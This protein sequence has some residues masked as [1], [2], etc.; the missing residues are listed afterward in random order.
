MKTE[1][2]ALTTMPNSIT[3]AKPASVSPPKSASGTAESS[4]VMEVPR[5]RFSVSLIDWSTSWRSGICLYLRRFSRIRS[6]T[7]TL[8]LAEKPMTVR[9]AATVV[10]LNST[11]NST[12]KPTV[13]VV[14]RMRVAMAAMANCHSKR[15]QM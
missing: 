13:L 2:E 3:Q 8:S 15:N 1:E 6:N 4:S 12:M 7:T 9:M 14:S 10:R 5:E 11:P